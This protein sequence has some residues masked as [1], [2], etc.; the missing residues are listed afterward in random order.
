MY[1]NY[2]FMFQSTHQGELKFNALVQIFGRHAVRVMY[3]GLAAFLSV[4]E[5]LSSSGTVKQME[6]KNDGQNFFQPA[7]YLRPAT[8]ING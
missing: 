4:L 1:M 7:G 2:D 5:I 3:S 8:L 6:P